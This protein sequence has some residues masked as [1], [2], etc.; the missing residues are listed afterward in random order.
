[1]REKQLGANRW[2]YALT[3]RLITLA[4]I[5]LL[6]LLAANSALAAHIKGKITLADGALCGFVD[7]FFDINSGPATV[8]IS[9]PTPATA[10]V[11][12]AGEY[13]FSVADSLFGSQTYE[14]TARCGSAITSRTIVVPAFSFFITFD[15]SMQVP[16]ARPTAA[17]TA[18]FNGQSVVGVRPGTKVR[19]SVRA[20][21]VDGDPLTIAWR[22]TDGTVSFPSTISARAVDWTLPNSPGLHFLYVLVSDGRAGFREERVAI[23]TDGTVVPNRPGGPAPTPTPFANRVPALDHFLAY[24]GEDSRQ[25]ACEYYNAIRAYSPLPV[26]SPG[27]STVCD[28]KGNPTLGGGFLTFASWKQ[29]VRLSAGGTAAAVYANLADLNLQRDMH[30]TTYRGSRPNHNGDTTISGGPCTPGVDC[31]VG[32][33]VAYYVCNHPNTGANLANATLHKNLVACVAMEYSETQI[34]SVS[35]TSTR[36]FLNGGNP[37]TKFYTFG[38]DGNLLPSVNLD[39]RGEKFMPGTCIAC[40][41]GPLAPFPTNPVT[42][43]GSVDLSANFLPFDLDNFQFAGGTGSTFATVAEQDNLRKLNEMLL[44][45]QPRPAITELV[46]GWYD[47]VAGNFV[48]NF[49]GTAFVPPGWTSHT[50][51]YNDVI[52]PACRTCHVSFSPDL[53]ASIQLTNNPRLKDSVSQKVCGNGIGVFKRYAMPN[54]LVAFERFWGSGQPAQLGAWLGVPCNP[55]SP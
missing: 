42:A 6:G 50:G 4:S 47:N 20:G 30:G 39:G 16:N 29:S 1:M 27:L 24:K 54:A 13:I 35:D 19:V 12:A 14:L 18:A 41:G 34:F 53:T 37:F 23:S 49:K 26:P 51:I 48:G 40:H 28:A 15:G 45:T 2:A 25:S 36:V 31:D 33:N 38:P 22:Q 55:P 21:D 3:R 46:N 11:D 9:G 7:P 17:L 5:S 52:R 10:T 32:T 43:N 8:D 44:K